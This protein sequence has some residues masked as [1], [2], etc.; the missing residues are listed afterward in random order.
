MTGAEWLA[1]TDPKPMLEFLTGRASD[2]KFQLFSAA[3][4][5][6]LYG[7]FPNAVIRQAVEFAERDSDGFAGVQEMLSVRAGIAAWQGSVSTLRAAHET[8]PGE[9][10]AVRAASLLVSPSP[11]RRVRLA[12]DA[13][14]RA[15]AAVSGSANDRDAQQRA[16]AGEEVR[17]ARA[18]WHATQAAWASERD[19]QAGLL[20]EI[21]GNPFY[22]LPHDR[23]WQGEELMYLA[24]QIYEQEAFE[25][26]GE[27][28]DA[29]EDAGCKDADILGH[30]RS[31]GLHVRGCW[32]IDRLLGKE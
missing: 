8:T 18:L 26:M 28:A 1:C 2:R 15:A 16:P 22:P 17:V 20:R 32:V 9:C 23:A 25:W 6:R 4:V 5:R 31:L 10:S 13:A 29:L 14:R 3:C 30:C 24:R 27:L 11:L 7:L 21:I 19:A 12:V